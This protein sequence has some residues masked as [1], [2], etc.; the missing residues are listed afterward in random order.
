MAISKSQTLVYVGK[1][2]I[3]SIFVLL[4][5][6]FLIFAFLRAIP[7]DPVM[8]MLGE[9]SEVSVEEYESIR[10]DLGLDRPLVVQ[11][12]YWLGRIAQGEFGTSIHTKEAVLPDVLTKLKTTLELAL[13]AVFIG[14][15]FGMIAGT[16][17]AVKRNSMFDHLAMVTAL[18]GISV[19]VFWMGILLIIFFGVE[20]NWLPISG[21]ASH[22]TELTPILGFPLIDSILSGNWTAAG[23]IIRHMI[24]PAITLAVVPAAITARTTRASMLEVINEDYINAGLARGLTFMQVLRRHALRNALIPV[25]TVIGLQIG[26]YLGGSIVTETVFSWPGLGRL[27]VDAIYN[28]DYPVVQGAIFIYAIMIVV[29]NLLVDIL[30]AYI[31]PRVEP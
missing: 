30:Y 14:S 10:R 2:C 4:A 28:R 18:I 3:H 9:G 12:A 7:G 5:L 1:R 31:D 17:S 25:V 23:D 21:L 22:D 11:Y 26:I 27:V 29:V 15:I 13:T 20:L 19:P 24:L 16:V 8:T 6:S